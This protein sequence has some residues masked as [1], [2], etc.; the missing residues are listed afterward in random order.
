VRWE[1]P[2]TS[3]ASGIHLKPRPGAFLFR[4]MLDYSRPVGYLP[5]RTRTLHV[6]T[7]IAETIAIS[8][9]H[10]VHPGAS[11]RLLAM[12]TNSSGKNGR[13][14]IQPTTM[15]I[16]SILSFFMIGLASVIGIP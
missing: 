14:E 15:I 1:R 2:E 7:M 8:S 5:H 6:S 16:P 9:I 11:L 12:L 10:R 13:L 4:A 3:R